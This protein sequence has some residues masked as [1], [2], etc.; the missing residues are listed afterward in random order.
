MDVQ[1]AYYAGNESSRT[2]PAASSFV[3]LASYLESQ[4]DEEECTEVGT[5]RDCLFNTDRYPAVS[6][7]RR[8]F[9]GPCFEHLSCGVRDEDLS[10]HGCTASPR[11][12][13]YIDF[14]KDQLAWWDKE[15]KKIR[16]SR[17]SSSKTF[18]RRSFVSTCIS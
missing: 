2:F 9:P 15:Y 3:K 18:P 8:C 10:S 13:R 12:K 7:T 17:L 16:E 5:S 6:G 4:T 11:V 14:L 1:C